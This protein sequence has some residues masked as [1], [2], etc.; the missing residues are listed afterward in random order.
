MVLPRKAASVRGSP[1]F[2]RRQKPLVNAV[3]AGA[4]PARRR[5]AGSRQIGHPALHPRRKCCHIAYTGGMVLCR[6]GATKR[7]AK[8]A[9]ARGG[10]LRMRIK[11]GQDL[12][13]GLLFV[14]V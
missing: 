8:T 12:A 4:G 1:V 13:T 9:Q 10:I 3:R 6:L 7:A 2:S 5:R 11:S 14:V